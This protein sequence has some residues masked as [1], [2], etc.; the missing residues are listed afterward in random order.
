MTRCLL[1]GL[2]IRS[3][4]VL[5]AGLLLS[6]VPRETLGRLAP[7][8]RWWPRYIAA[9]AV[10]A[11][12]PGVAGVDRHA[13][14]AHLRRASRDHSHASRKSGDL[15][16]CAAPA[17]LRPRH[18][19][20]LSGAG[21]STR[22]RQLPRRL[23]LP[24]S[25]SPVVFVSAGT[26]IAGLVRVTSRRRPC[27]AR[28]GHA[29]AA[30]PR[31][32]RR[33]LRTDPGD[34]DLADRFRRPAG[35][36]GH[37][38]AAGAR[39]PPRARLDAGSRARRP[40]PRTGAHPSSRLARADGRRSAA[41]DPLVQSAVWMVCTR[42]RRES[43]QACDDEVLDVGV[44]GREYAAHLIELARQCRRPGFPW[45]IG[46]ADGSPV[47]PG[48]EN[49]RHVESATRPPGAVVACPGHAR[50]PPSAG[51]AAGRRPS[52]APGRSGAAIRNHLRR[53]RCACC[54]ASRLRSWMRTRSGQV[55]TSNATGRFEFP[56]VGPGKYVLEVTLAGFRALRQEFELRDAR[57]WDRAV[58][59]QV[60]D[61]TETVI[62]RE[63]R[64]AVSTAA[65][66]VR[67]ASPE[68][69]R[70]GG[71]IR[72]P[73]KEWTSVRSIRRRCATP[74]S[75]GSCRSRRVIGSDGAV[76]SV[77]VLSAQVHPGLRDRGRRCR[78]AVALHAHA[79]QWRAGRS[80]D[81]GQHHF[82]D[83]KLAD[84]SQLT[85]VSV[86]SESTPVTS[87]SRDKFDGGEPT[88]LHR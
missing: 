6:A 79:P 88:N 82:R 48:E 4:V 9:A 64:V 27:D 42:L 13:A 37:P 75:P 56:P 24:S 63:S 2:A 73:R 10:V 54:R 16:T 32:G 3:S 66:A 59:L 18:L 65:G 87:G 22:A 60:G 40:L 67:A 17:S 30:G 70:V 43:E 35:H 74:A 26:L 44:G 36:V 5:A 85:A 25:G 1:I 46:D 29:L 28:R 33:A 77:R 47:N 21:G 31:H 51:H 76:S 8:R 41:R 72:A 58:T 34:R 57:D 20:A 15:C 7:P 71:N 50:R 69:V 81:D 86:R 19:G 62:V 45:A 61:L 53:H 78:A 55:A 12:Q 49:C 83:G 52:R 11:V 80:G 84:S 14:R 68:R 39:P 23:L 38:A